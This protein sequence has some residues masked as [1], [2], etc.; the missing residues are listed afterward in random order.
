[1]HKTQV[2]RCFSAGLESNHL[3]ESET[4]FVQLDSD[5]TARLI[6]LDSLE[7]T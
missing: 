2:R 5:G 4:H 3:L 1:L 6:E 7:T